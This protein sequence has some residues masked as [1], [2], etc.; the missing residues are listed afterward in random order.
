MF[1]TQAKHVQRSGGE[2]EHGTLEEMKEDCMNPLPRVQWD[3][4]KFQLPLKSLSLTTE[5]L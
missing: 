2:G 5:V 3:S 1:E 4:D